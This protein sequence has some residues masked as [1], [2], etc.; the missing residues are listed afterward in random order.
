MALEGGGSRRGGLAS[1]QPYSGEQSHTTEGRQGENRRGARLVTSRED[2][3]TI[4][5]RPRHDGSRV[6]G[7]GAAAVRRKEPVSVDRAKQRGRE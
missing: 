6:D 5:R 4:E 3:R 2:S 7:G 1:A